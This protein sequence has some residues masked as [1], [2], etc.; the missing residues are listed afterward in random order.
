MQYSYTHLIAFRRRRRQARHG[1]QHGLHQHPLLSVLRHRWPD[2]I[3]GRRGLP[4]RPLR[5]RR[6]GLPSARRSSGNSTGK[7][8]PISGTLRSETVPPWAWQMDLTIAS[9]SPAPTSP[10]SVRDTIETVEDP[11]MMVRVDADAG[12][13]HGDKAL[14]AVRCRSRTAT[15]PPAGVYLMALSTRLT[16]ICFSRSRS[17]ATITG[18]PDGRFRRSAFPPP[19][20]SSGRWFRRASAADRRWHGCACPTGSPSATG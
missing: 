7:Q 8:L 20:G 1:R 15:R 17:P 14:V 11:V 2:K 12:I 4:R 9:P 6:C 3:G 18:G 19:A 16:S 5:F 10:R 13:L